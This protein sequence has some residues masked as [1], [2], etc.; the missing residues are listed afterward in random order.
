[1]TNTN[2]NVNNKTILLVEYD[3]KTASSGRLP[4]SLSDESRPGYL[5]IEPYMESSPQKLLI[6]K[7][8]GFTALQSNVDPDLWL[9]SYNSETDLRKRRNI[10][11]TYY[12][13]LAA[14]S[15]MQNKVPK[16]A[17]ST[18]NT[19]AVL[20]P[21]YMAEAFSLSHDNNIHEVILRHAVDK[22]MTHYKIEKM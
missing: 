21:R 7:A 14:W 13:A 5:F 15:R 16:L 19:D 10:I 8:L 6:E 2:K 3:G 1:M 9:R 22:P 11:G 18:G 20:T 4:N 12:I 17:D